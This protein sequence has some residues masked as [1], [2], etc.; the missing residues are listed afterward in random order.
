MPIGL[1]GKKLG[2]TRIHD[3]SGMI[4]PVTVIQAGPCSILQVKNKDRD[5]YEALQLGFDARPEGGVNKPMMGHFK[6]SGSK[7][8]RFVREFRTE[9][10]AEY[11]QGQV[12]DLGL[13][14]V[15]E[16]VDVVGQSKGRGFAGS[17]KRHHNS[18]GPMSHGSMYHRRPGSLGQSSDPS[19]VYKNKPQPGQMGNERV[20][21]QNLTIMELDKGRNLILVRGSVPGA[22]N[23]YVMIQKSKKALR[24]AK[25]R[26]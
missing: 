24:R 22:P 5:G 16:K 25:A 23:G 17:I 4:I 6:A 1:L 13:F 2:M 7:P 10:S 3:E 11:E 15:G 26:A 12:L 14:E 19:R 9:A 21:T 18:S 8:V 20:M